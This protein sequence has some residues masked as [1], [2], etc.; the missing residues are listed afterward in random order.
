MGKDTGTQ[1]KIDSVRALRAR[2]I[3]TITSMETTYDHS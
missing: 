2:T 1:N 3:G